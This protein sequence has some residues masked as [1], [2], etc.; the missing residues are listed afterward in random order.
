MAAE[1]LRIAERRLDGEVLLERDLA[2]HSRLSPAFS[3]SCYA[4][5]TVSKRATKKPPDMGSLLQPKPRSG[6]GWWSQAGSNRRPP[7]C[8]AGA[9]PAELWPH[10]ETW[11]GDRYLLTPTGLRNQVSSSFSTPSPMISLTSASP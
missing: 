5:A 4:T 8:H 9:L 1:H 6:E 10:L 3:A 7:A 11:I 2:L